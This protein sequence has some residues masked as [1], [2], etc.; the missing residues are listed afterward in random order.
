VFR[1]KILNPAG[2]RKNLTKSGVSWTR[3]KKGKADVRQSRSFAAHP[4]TRPRISKGGRRPVLWPALHGLAWRA[5][6]NLCLHERTRRPVAINA[7]KLRSVP[8]RAATL[9]LERP[10]ACPGRKTNLTRGAHEQRTRQT[11]TPHIGRTRKGS[12]LLFG[13][14]MCKGIACRIRG[15]QSRGMETLRR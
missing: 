2:Y 10:L 7:V 1:N 3:T 15:T 13:R 12:R 9:M 14:T 6:N 4:A 11:T 5:A 8:S